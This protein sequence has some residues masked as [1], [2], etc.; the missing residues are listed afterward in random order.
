MREESSR[1]SEKRKKFK[2][3]IK[4]KV[5]KNGSSVS[6]NGELIKNIPRKG[7]KGN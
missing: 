2:G 5:S 6:K 3:L 4:K 1:E 7:L